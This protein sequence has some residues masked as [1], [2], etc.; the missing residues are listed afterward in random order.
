MIEVTEL[1][2]E[3][4]VAQVFASV[5]GLV[6]EKNRRY[7]DSALMPKRIFSKLPCDEGIKIRLDDK[8][9]RIINSGEVRKNDVA[10][11]MGYLCL[12]CISK[13]W[14]DFEDLID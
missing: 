4:K 14:L 7:G 12:L 10:D 13:D 2:T 9:S 3:G 6:K 1:G 8:V 11:L 5:A